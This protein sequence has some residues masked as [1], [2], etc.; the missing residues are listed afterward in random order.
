[1]LSSRCARNRALYALPENAECRRGRKR[2][3][4]QKAGEAGRGGG[5]IVS[6]YRILQGNPADEKELLPSLENHLRLFGREPWLVAADRGVYSA[7]N[8]EAARGIGVRRVALPKKRGPRTKSAS[9]TSG[10]GGF[11][12]RGGFGRASR[13]E[14]A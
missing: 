7:A 3:Y 5:G 8:A 11:E 13:G 12:E 9:A 4:G 6:V 1:M 10:K 14:S 2:K